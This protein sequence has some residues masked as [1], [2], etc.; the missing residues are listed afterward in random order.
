ALASLATS[1][2]LLSIPT[3]AELAALLHMALMATVVAFVLWYS[4]VARLGA[5][6]AGLF[7]G[8]MPVAGYLAGLVLGTSHWA[9]PA[10]LG[11]ALCGAGVA[12]GLARE[13]QPSRARRLL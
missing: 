7:C 10:L 3:V 13:P 9:M 2:R 11:T 1:E 6:R 4:G 5:D 12:V 8:V